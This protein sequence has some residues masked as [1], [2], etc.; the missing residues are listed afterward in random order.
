M[1]FTKYGFNVY[2]QEE[3]VSL[4]EANGLHFVQATKTLNEP[5]AEFDEQSIKVESLCIVAE[6]R[7]LQ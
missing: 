2:R 3:W 7:K 5:D 1:P 6:K 4:L